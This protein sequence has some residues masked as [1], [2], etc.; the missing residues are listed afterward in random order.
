MKTTKI[1]VWSMIEMIEVIQRLCLR[2]VEYDFK[3]CSGGN[4]SLR[5][6]LD[7]LFGT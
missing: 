3:S 4:I 7:F 6:V 2:F 5:I 1:S